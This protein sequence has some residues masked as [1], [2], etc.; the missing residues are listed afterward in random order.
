M[1]ALIVVAIAVGLVAA[2]AAQQ[3]TPADRPLISVETSM[4]MLPVSVVDRRGGFVPGLTRENFTVYD[5]GAPRP[6]A[7]FAADDVPVTIG[8]VIDASSSMARQRDGVTAAASAFAEL[9]HPGNEL[10][11]IHFNEAVW[12]GLPPAVAFAESLDQLRAALARAPARGMTALYDAVWRGLDHLT[13]FGTRDR[14]ALVVVSDGGD[15]A[16][17]HTLGQVLDRARRT[18]AMI[19]AVILADPDDHDARPDVL[20]TLARE[21]G[22]DA[23]APA[24]VQ[25]L[26]GGFTRI[27]LEIRSGYTIGF[28]PPDF[29]GD[30]FRATRVVVTTGARRPVTV[31][32]RA[33]YYAGPSKRGND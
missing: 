27:A 22:G 11:T 5:N 19:Y 8:L 14:R 2:A 29:A 20:R 9:S 21:T 32:T 28:L 7:F 1:R 15:N 17:A 3:P 16:S 12:T 33:G 4:V 6:I 23:V 26:L 18:N 31:R 10:F 24:R 25:D 30:E 13:A